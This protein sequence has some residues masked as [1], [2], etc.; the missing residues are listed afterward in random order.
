MSNAEQNANPHAVSWFEIPVIDMDR[1]QKFY[2]VTLGK[3]LR[4][5]M[6]PMADKIYPL[7]IFPAVD[8]GATGCL[9]SGHD[10]LASSTQGSLV[11]LACGASLDAAVARAIKAGGVV[12]KA[13]TALPPGMGFFAHLQDLDGNRVALHALAE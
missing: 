2:E 12:L 9:M 4:R 13:K 7:A 11:Y 6:F 3:T 5:E 10:T 1:A 8:G